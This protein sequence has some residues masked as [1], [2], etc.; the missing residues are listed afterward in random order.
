MKH[1][2]RATRADGSLV[3][4]RRDFLGAIGRADSHDA[5]IAWIPLPLTAREM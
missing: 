3:P 5:G 2:G 4:S 1:S